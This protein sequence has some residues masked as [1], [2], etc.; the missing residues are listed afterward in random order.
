MI[1]TRRQFLK[2]S[3]ASAA[4]PLVLSACGRAAEVASSTAAPATPTS[5]A[6]R[7]AFERGVYR[8]LFVERGKGEPEIAAKSD[9]AWQSLFAS[10]DDTRRVYYP[11]GENEHGPLAYVK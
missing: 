1:Y 4:V 8:N 10:P 9:A 11:A 5:T 2:L 7:P 6:P 3:A